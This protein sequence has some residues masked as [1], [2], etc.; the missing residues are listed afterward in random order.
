M[1]SA[2]PAHA[3]TAGDRDL[4]ESIW[5]TT[6]ARILLHNESEP[7]LRATITTFWHY[8]IAGLTALLRQ[9]RPPL[10]TKR[11]LGPHQVCSTWVPGASKVIRGGLW[12][13]R[14]GKLSW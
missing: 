10:T 9:P 6:L 12:C 4:L 7:T 8:Q 11:P 13:R 2:L 5:S 1:A 3:V 14:T